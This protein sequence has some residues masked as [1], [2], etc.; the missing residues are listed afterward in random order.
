MSS[1][2]STPFCSGQWNAG[3]T[4]QINKNR[5]GFVKRTVYAKSKKLERAAFIIIVMLSSVI[6]IGCW[7]ETDSISRKTYLSLWNAK[8][9]GCKEPVNMTAKW[10]PN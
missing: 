1:L 4:L 8:N 7:M 3:S 6:E 5:R 9:H 10:S 2:Y